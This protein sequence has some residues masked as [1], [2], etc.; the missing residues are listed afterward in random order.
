M[1]NYLVTVVIA[2]M[3]ASVVVTMPVLFAN[4]LDG[5]LGVVAGFAAAWVTGFFVATLAYLRAEDV[6]KK[7]IGRLIFLR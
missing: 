1:V 3:L 4:W 6:V 7:A 5:S 2:T